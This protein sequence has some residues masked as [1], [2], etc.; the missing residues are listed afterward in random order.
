VTLPADFPQRVEHYFSSS[1]VEARERFRRAAQARGAN[2]ESFTID[3]WGLHGEELATDVA[4]IASP[5]AR[6]LL[7]ITSATH[8]VE[9]FCG[10]GCQLALLD[11]DALLACAADAGIALLL[12]HAINPYGFSWLSRAN[13]NN[14]DLNRNAQSFE[15]PLPGNPDYAGLHPLLVPSVWPPTAENEQ[16]IA[17]ST[18]ILMA[19][20]LAAPSAASRC[21]RCITCCKLMAAVMTTSAGSMSTRV[22]DP[23]ETERRSSLDAV[24][25]RRLRA[26]SG[27]GAGTL[28]CPLPERPHQPTLPAT[29]HRPFT[30]LAPLRVTH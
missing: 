7:I 1:Y 9:G 20:F 10:S 26:L 16:A 21:A 24:I 11:D 19:F 29:S 25:R 23:T 28:P 4:L 17:D 3:A 6:G 27:G 5:G 22:W 12:V 15:A 14:I 2:L 18:R 13:E 8:G 30:P